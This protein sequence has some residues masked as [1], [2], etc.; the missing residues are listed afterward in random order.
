MHVQAN[1]PHPLAK[2]TQ[3]R[4]T[5]CMCTCRRSAQD[6]ASSCPESVPKYSVEQGTSLRRL[7]PGRVRGSTRRGAP[8]ALQLVQQQKQTR[9]SRTCNTVQPPLRPTMPTANATENKGEGAAGRPL[10]SEGL[11][12]FS[13]AEEHLRKDA[14]SGASSQQGGP[15]CALDVRAHPRLYIAQTETSTIAAAAHAGMQPHRVSC[16]H[17]L[18]Q[19]LDPGFNRSC[20]HTAICPQPYI[21]PAPTLPLPGGVSWRQTPR[22]ATTDACHTSRLTG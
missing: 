4:R 3:R 18:W 13:P 7:C 22:P 12:T 11:V 14:S 15:G 16:Q 17:N 10:P 9:K 6:T 5:D 20:R 19:R 8:G 2:Q 21:Q 1:D